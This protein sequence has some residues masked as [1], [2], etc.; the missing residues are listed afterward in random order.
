M[1]AVTMGDR[2]CAELVRTELPEDRSMRPTVARVDEH[3]T[4]DVRVHAISKRQRK[5]KNPLRNLFQG[6]PHSIHQAGD[7]GTTHRQPST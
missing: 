1:I 3:L 2:V 4:D 5:M 6:Q 7:E